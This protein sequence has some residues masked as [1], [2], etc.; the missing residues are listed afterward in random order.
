MSST[1][2]TTNNLIKIKIRSLINICKI[3][4]DYEIQYGIK[5]KVDK[6]DIIALELEELSND[7]EMGSIK[8]LSD[9]FLLMNNYRNLAI[10]DDLN[11]KKYMACKDQYFNQY[12]IFIKK[13]N[14]I[15]KISRYFNILKNITTIMSDVISSNK[16]YGNKYNTI[17]GNTIMSNSA[18]RDTM[19]SIKK[20]FIAY[21]NST[22]NSSVSNN[23][24]NKCNTCNSEMKIISNLSEITCTICGITENLYGTVFEDEQFYYQEGRR[25]KHGSYDPSKHCKFWLERIQA[26]ESKEIPDT[27]INSIK[28]Y[29]NTNN[30]RNKEDI[31][32][33]EIRKYLSHTRNSSYNE[34]IPLIRKIITGEAPEQLTDKELQ[35]ITIYFD[36]VIRIYEEIKPNEKTNVPYHPYLIYKIIEHIL[37]SKTQLFTQKKRMHNILSYIHLQS[38]VTLIENDNTWREISKFIPEIKYKPTDRNSQEDI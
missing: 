36:K 38:R 32:C 33:R 25:S 4:K 23:I 12:Q 26:K 27:I 15:S 11:K 18:M 28:E 21:E 24:Y 20:L 16:K 5:D 31:T 22:I 35:L 8:I 30:I 1:L 13:E 7:Y 37:S 19:S 6:I 3:I 29:L 9:Y 2:E 17:V 14:F 34:H 10:V